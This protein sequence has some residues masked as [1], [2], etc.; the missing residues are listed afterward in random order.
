[1]RGACARGGGADTVVGKRGLIWSSKLI[2]E[3]LSSAPQLKIAT[4]TETA[5]ATPALSPTLATIA[6]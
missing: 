3:R 6:W 1:M 4:G 2:C 5:A